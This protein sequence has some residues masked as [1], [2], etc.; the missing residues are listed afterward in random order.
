MTVFLRVY[1]AFVFLRTM[2][3]LVSGQLLLLDVIV[4]M[5]PDM[6]AVYS[7]D[8]LRTWCMSGHVM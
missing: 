5:T 2:P 8:A 4:R 7:S 1:V 6:T 3:A